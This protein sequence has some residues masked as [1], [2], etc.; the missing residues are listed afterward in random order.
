LQSAG[1]INE[2]I[3]TV[4]FADLPFQVAVDVFPRARLNDKAGATS[5]VINDFYYDAGPPVTDI[6]ALWGCEV[7]SVVKISVSPW[8]KGR[9]II[10]KIF[11]RKGCTLPSAAG[12]HLLGFTGLR[13][14]WIGLRA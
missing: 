3:P 6:A 2:I 12:G 4:G 9:G 7:K 13:S 10:L 1:T 11:Y 14:D 8:A 5:T